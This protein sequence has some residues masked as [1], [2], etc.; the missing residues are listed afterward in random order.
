[1]HSRSLLTVLF[2]LLFVLSCDKDNVNPSGDKQRLIINIQ[3]EYTS[4]PSKVSIFFKVEYSDGTP[5]SGLTQDNFTI[6]EQ[7]RNDENFKEISKDE[8]DRVIADNAPLFNYN[9]ILL[10]DLSGSVI[11]NN[12]TELKNASVEFVNE[13]LASENTSTQVGIWWFDGNDKLHRLINFSNQKADLI[14]AINS[15]DGGTPR[16]RSTDLFGAIMKGTDL[17]EATIQQGKLEDVLTAAS[18]IVFTDGTDQAARYSRDEALSMVNKADQSINYYTIG[19]GNEIDSDVLKK[20]GKTSSVF[21]NDTSKLNDKFKEIA[22]LIS[23]EA[24][25]YYLFEYCT[26]KRDGSGISKLRMEVETD[27]SR[28]TKDTDFDATGFKSGVC[29]L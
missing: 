20:I 27:D 12:L 15:I 16:D 13:A 3:D 6:Y 29:G 23:G 25:S 24:N 28:G 18:I 7:G 22:N 8:A 11:N 21:A 26:P 19:L 10:L 14:A 9:T 17:A 5:V 4:P 1:M 2:A